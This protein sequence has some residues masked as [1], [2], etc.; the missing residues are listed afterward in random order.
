MS[1]FL[2]V[3]YLAKLAKLSVK[4]TTTSGQVSIGFAVVLI[5]ILMAIS[6]NRVWVAAADVEPTNSLPNPYR[7]IADWANLPNGRSWGS[8]AGVSVD[9]NGNIWVAERCGAN[10]CA[11]SNLAPILEFDPSG[12]LLTSFGTG[13][14]IFPHGITVDRDGKDALLTVMG[15][16]EKGIG[17]EQ[18]PMRWRRTATCCRRTLI[19]SWKRPEDIGIGR[20]R[21]LRAALR[22]DTR[23]SF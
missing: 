21:R 7:T 14:F 6:A 8:T 12:K 5:A 3:S 4:K 20:C 17:S 1:K 10:T 2:R 18:P 23:W 15:K 22:T 16:T 19:L 13:M 11:G 9:R